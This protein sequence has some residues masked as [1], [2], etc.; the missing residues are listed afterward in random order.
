MRRHA[1]RT[2]KRKKRFNSYKF[3]RLF[4]RKVHRLRSSIDATFFNASSRRSD[5]SWRGS[6]QNPH[7]DRRAAINWKQRLKV[8]TIFIA[9]AITAWLLLYHA[10]FQINTISVQGLVRVN[11][12][13]MLET[14]HATMGGRHMMIIP[15]TN[16]FFYDIK[17]LQSIIEEKYPIERSI[18]EKDFPNGIAITVEEKI[19]NLIYD[20]SKQY[21]YVNFDG[22]VVEIKQNVDPSEF[23]EI[24]EVV[25]STLADGTVRSETNVLDRYHKPNVAAVQSGMGDFPILYDTRHKDASVN[26]KVLENGIAESVVSWFNYLSKQTDIPVLYFELTDA[27][28]REVVIYTTEGWNIKAKLDHVEKQAEELQLVLNEKVQRQNLEY[29]DLRFFGRVYWK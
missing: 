6:K 26:E 13:E 18:I 5:F 21:S 23:K 14:V 2:R 9:T 29:I 27:R 16:Y 15:R 3:E 24:T 8:W 1:R 28:G 22:Y 12:T 11:Q 7:V 17:E 4:K 10:T 19:T 25:T 20:N